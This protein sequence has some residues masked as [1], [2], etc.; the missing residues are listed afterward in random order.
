MT[1][2]EIELL[3]HI[4]SRGDDHP[5]EKRMPPVYQPTIA[6]FLEEKLIEPNP[7]CSPPGTPQK[8]YVTTKR[9]KAYVELGLMRVTLPVK[10][11]RIPSANWLGQSHD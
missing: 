11:W 3:L 10:E 4:Y 7:A 5:D 1:P 2:Y 9:G 6:A 8:T